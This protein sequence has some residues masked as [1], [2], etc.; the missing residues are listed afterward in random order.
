MKTE[1]QN[2]HNRCEFLQ[3]FI[4]YQTFKASF[5]K[6]KKTKKFDGPVFEL[7]CLKMNEF[8]FDIIKTDYKDLCFEKLM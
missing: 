2:F 5:V 6:E 7:M 8:C 4:P 1:R 3:D